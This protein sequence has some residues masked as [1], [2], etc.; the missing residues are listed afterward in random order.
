MFDVLLRAACFVGVILLGYVLRKINFFKDGDFD[1]LAKVAL[2]ITLPAAVICNCNGSEVSVAMLGLSLVG[3]GGG[4][5][6]MV[7]LYVMNLRSSR[8]QRA[9]EVLNSTG[10]NIG[11]F[12]MPFAQSFLGPVG[13]LV[14][15]LFDTGN[16][17]VCLGGAYSISSMIKGE[18]SGNG[19]FSLKPIVKKLLA[20]PPFDTYVLMTILGLL[21]ISFPAPVISYAQIIANANAFIAML[22]IGVGFRLSGDMTQIGAILRILIVRYGIALAIALGCYFVLPLPLEYRQTL[23]IIVFAPIASAAPA[24]TSELKGDV[25]L[26]SAINSLSILISLV[27][28]VA[29][30]LILL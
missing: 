11:N 2:K 21:H 10:Y 8:E 22:M 26:S 16:A 19:G 12:T 18:E 20:S 7:I 23:A 29:A 24:F 4:V 15:S 25:G 13:V 6:Y 27:C 17:F 3:F 14:T 1:V 30:I 5:L 9:F 28:M